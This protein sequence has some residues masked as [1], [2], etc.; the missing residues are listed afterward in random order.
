MRS[1][2]KLGCINEDRAIPS[3][4]IGE[5]YPL[6]GRTARQVAH[7]TAKRRRSAFPRPAAAL[8]EQKSCVGVVLRDFL[9]DPRGLPLLIESC[10]LEYEIRDLA[11]M[12]NQRYVAGIN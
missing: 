12:G 3:F 4:E 8:R 7:I 6:H 1:N 10:G 9:A 5:C 2:R 11:W